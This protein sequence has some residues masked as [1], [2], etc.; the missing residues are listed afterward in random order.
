M[1]IVIIK[2]MLYQFLHPWH[3]LTYGQNTSVIG[4][5][6]L[7][8]YTIYTRRMMLLA[9]QTRRGELYP[10]I[11]LQSTEVNY[12]E[13]DFFIVNV[14]AGLLLNAFEWGQEVSGQFKIGETFY[15]PSHE[16]EKKFIGTMVGQGQGTLTLHR[17]VD[18]TELRV[19]QIIEGTDSFGGRHQFCILRSFVSPGNYEHQVRMIHPAD[20]LPFWRRVALKAHEWRARL[21]HKGSG[22]TS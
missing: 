7:V 16:I 5:V 18:G 11:V 1:G 13:L 10:M 22:K 9:Q 12:G 6:V 15:E 19:L 2:S 3:W 14:G 17:K 8:F 20:F 21:Q 4:L